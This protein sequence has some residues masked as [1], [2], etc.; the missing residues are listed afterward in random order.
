MSKTG[1]KEWASKDCDIYYGCSNDCRYGYCRYTYTVRLA[2][3]T[4]KTAEN[5]KEMV[6]REKNFNE[7]P[8]KVDGRLFCFAHH[9]ITKDNVDMCI[10]YMKKHLEVGNEILIVTKP[11]LECVKKICSALEKYGHQIT[12]RFTIGSRNDKVLKFWDRNAPNYQERL[13]ALVWAYL[14]GFKTSVSCEPYLD[15]EIAELVKDIQDYVTD[16][17]WIGKM[18]KMKSRVDTKDFTDD[19]WKYYHIV[20][21][22]QTDEQ[23]K[24]IYEKLKDNIK[25]RWKDSIK[26]VLKLP[27]EDIG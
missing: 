10:Q 25:I 20:E 21:R 1:T 3:R 22:C 16:T 7:K 4:G 2:K 14:E 11:S 8:K 26:K 9:D 15:F 19:D 13:N 18:N 17:I 24:I 27:E 5:W 6:F 12:F 23:V